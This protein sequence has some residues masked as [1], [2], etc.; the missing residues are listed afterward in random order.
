MP[1]IDSSTLSGE[2]RRRNPPESRTQR[3]RCATSLTRVIGPGAA[4]DV[5]DALLLRAVRNAHTRSALMIALDESGS[6]DTAWARDWLRCRAI[7]S[8]FGLSLG[9]RGTR[10][11]RRQRRSAAVGRGGGD[12]VSGD[13]P[14]L[15][16]APPRARAPARSLPREV[17]RKVPYCLAMCPGTLKVILT[18]LGALLELGGIGLVVVDVA[19]TRRDARHVLEADPPPEGPTRTVSAVRAT[20]Y[21]VEGL[22]PELVVRPVSSLIHA[23]RTL[24]A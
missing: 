4:S 14:A 9:L 8:D 1:S 6:A 5:L 16:A 17:Q 7:T 21:E 23:S 20:P 18:I 22:E 10:W 24:P 11:R 19:R 15:T 12:G 2:W 3:P 13:R